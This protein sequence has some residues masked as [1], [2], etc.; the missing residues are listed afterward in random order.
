MPTT[1]V[2]QAKGVSVTRSSSPK[3]CLVQPCFHQNT[4]GA[5]A[6]KKDSPA[7]ARTRAG[8]MSRN[9]SSAGTNNRA[10]IKAI[11]GFEGLSGV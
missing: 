5:G 9:D 3:G 11:S 2:K 6:A 7:K 4:P 8:E 10:L 1:F